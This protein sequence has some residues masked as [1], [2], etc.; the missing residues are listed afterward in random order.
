MRVKSGWYESNQGEKEGKPGRSP[1]TQKDW[2][3]CGW[4]QVVTVVL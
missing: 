4:G 2:R 1:G 3:V